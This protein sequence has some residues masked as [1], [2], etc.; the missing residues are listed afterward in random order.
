MF[1]SKF[2]EDPTYGYIKIGRIK[3][4]MP[5]DDFSELNTIHVK[6]QEIFYVSAG[7]D[8]GS[9]YYLGP[10]EI[11][12]DPDKYSKPFIEIRLNNNKENVLKLYIIKKSNKYYR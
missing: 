9:L 11:I 12:R 7:C 2:E 3:P 4:R 10:Q 1:T 8:E 6:S 5:V